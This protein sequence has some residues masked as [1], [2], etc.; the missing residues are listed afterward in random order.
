MDIMT[1][2]IAAVLVLILAGVLIGLFFALRGGQNNPPAEKTAASRPDL[3]EVA[4]LERDKG[5]NMLMVVVDGK[6]YANASNLSFAQRQK[7]ASATNDLHKWLG[8]PA[9]AAPT[10]AAAAFTPTPLAVP[11]AVQTLVDEAAIAPVK[12]VSTNPVEALRHTIGTSKPVPAFK[13]IPAQIDEILQSK[14]VGTALEK[15]GI[16]LVESPTEGVV[17]QIGL[18]QYPGVGAVPDDEV[19][20][21]I[22]SAVAE[23]EKRNR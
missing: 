4:R 23:W 17:V 1:I 14:L 11:P 13:S 7:L 22:R 16:H 12:P 10:S 15:R 6:L 20:N 3:V 9:A 8:L 18:E 5:T 21:L 19:R 2:A